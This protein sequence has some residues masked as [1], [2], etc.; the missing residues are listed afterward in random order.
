MFHKWHDFNRL[1]GQCPKNSLT[2]A[3]PELRNK[4]LHEQES[5][6][7]TVY[8]LGFKVRSMLGEPGRLQNMRKNALKLARPDAGDLIARFAA[9]L[10]A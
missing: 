7:D 5:F 10:E 2:S 4:T 9:S 6:R 3:L 8:T 1:H